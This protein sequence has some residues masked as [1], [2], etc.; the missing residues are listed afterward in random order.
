M[1]R[2]IV[3]HLGYSITVDY[4]KDIIIYSTVNKFLEYNPPCK[5]CLV[6]G[7]C[8]YKKSSYFINYERSNLHIGNET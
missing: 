5:E 8:L 4:N 2:G 7:I 3:E 6:Q 1:K